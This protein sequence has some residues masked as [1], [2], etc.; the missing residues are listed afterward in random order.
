MK[1]NDDESEWYVVGSGKR[2]PSVTWN[3]DHAAASSRPWEC[4]LELEPGVAVLLQD[5]RDLP[6]AVRE[7]YGRELQTDPDGQ[8]DAS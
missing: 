8:C 4:L 2:I 3:C 7:R 6:A 1:S 5:V